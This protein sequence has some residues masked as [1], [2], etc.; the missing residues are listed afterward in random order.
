MI[1]SND[2]KLKGLA[3]E[4]A[5]FQDSDFDDEEHRGKQSTKAFTYKDQ[6]R[7]DVLRKADGEDGSSDEDEEDLFS[8]KKKDGETVFEEEARLKKEFKQA[9]H[10]DSDEEGEAGG[11][12]L[13]KKGGADSESEAESLPEDIQNLKPEKVLKVASKKAKKELKMET[14]TDLL[15][16]FY[17]DESQLD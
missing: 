2:P 7:Q 11:F 17:G 8:K 15:K 4:Q 16:R 14:D 3:P 10:G 12:T 9:Q 6:I 13:K 1:R 5:V